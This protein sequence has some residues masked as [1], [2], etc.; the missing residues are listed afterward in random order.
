MRSLLDLSSQ[1]TQFTSNHSL[2]LTLWLIGAKWLNFSQKSLQNTLPGMIWFESA[3]PARRACR[4]LKAAGQERASNTS[5]E[6]WRGVD[7]T[8]PNGARGPTAMPPGRSSGGSRGPI[9]ASRCALEASRR[10]S[11]GLS[12]ISASG[13]WLY[14][15]IR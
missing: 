14:F 8:S 2:Y 11:K 6:T 5:C 7:S 13:K 4:I 9:G 10:V 1:L 15:T 3:A 12:G